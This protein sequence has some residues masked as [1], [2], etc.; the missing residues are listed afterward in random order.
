MSWDVTLHVGAWGTNLQDW[1]S[2]HLESALFKGSANITSPA[3][4]W[5]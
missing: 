1:H 4:P 5:L 3:W 2:L